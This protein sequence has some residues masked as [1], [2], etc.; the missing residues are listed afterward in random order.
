MASV[1][2]TGDQAPP[3]PPPPAETIVVHRPSLGWR[4]FGWVSILLGALLIAAA[5]FLLW[6]NTDSGRQ[7]IVK[8]VNDLQFASGLDITIERI[9]GSIWDEMTVH[10]LTLADERGVFFEAREAQ[11]RYSPI[12]YLTESHIDI[13]SLAIPYARLSRN[14][15]LKSTGDP[16][17]PLI[18]NLLLDIG[19]L[20]I[21]RLQIERPGEPPHVLSVSGEIHLKDSEALTNLRIRALAEQGRAGGDDISLKLDLAPE[22]NR[23]GIELLLDA[24]AN[25]FLASLTGIERRMRVDVRGRGEWANWQGWAKAAMDDQGFADLRVTAQNGRFSLSGPTRP[26]LFVTGPAERLTGPYTQLNTVFT[27]NDRRLTLEEFRL[28]SR[29]AVIVADGTVN[30]ADNVYEDLR[31]ATR[32]LQ[33]GAIAPNLAGRD[34]RLAMV[35]NGSMSTPRVAYDLRAASLSFSERTLVNFRATGAARVD[36]DRIV[37]PVA[38]S[39]DRLEGLPEQLGGLLTNVRLNGDLLVEGTNIVSDNLRLRSDRAD[40]VL[41]IAFDIGR[42]R[43]NV[44]IQGRVNEFLIESVGVVDITSDFDVVSQGGGFGLQGRVAVRTRRI[45]N[46]SAVDLLGGMATATARIAIGGDGAIRFGDLRVTAPQLRITEGGGVYYPDGRIALQLRGTSTRYGAIAVNVGGT[47]SAPQVRLEIAEVGF[48]VGLRG[49]TATIRATAGGY[50]IQAEGQSNY[51]PFS[52]DV[53][54][55]TGIARRT[56]YRI[57]SLLFA[58][59]TFRGQIEQTAQ[60]PFAGGLSVAGRGIDGNVVLAAAGPRQRVE[61]DAV[62]NDAVIPSTLSGQAEIAIQRAIVDL[63][64]T[65]PTDDDPFFLYAAGGRVEVAGL[66]SGAFTLAQG[67]A[68]LNFA[69]NAG[70]AKFLAVGSSGV[71]FN[72]AGNAA[73]TPERVR[74]ALQGSAN[75]IPFRFA[76]PAVIE[77]EGGD[78]ILRPTNV[79]FREGQGTMRLAGRFGSSGTIIQSRLDSFD[80][81]IAN[82]LRPGLG[83][84][85]HATGSLDF[86]LPTGGAFPRAEARLNIRNFTRT[87]IA[88]RSVPVDISFSGNLRPEGG[89]LAAVFRQNDAVIGRAQARLQPLPPGAGGWVDRLIAAPFSGGVRYNGPASV[90]TSLAGLSGHQLQGPVAVG[91]DFSG[92]INNPELVGVARAQ[93]VTYTNETYG[94]RISNLVLDG[95]F[96]GSQLDIVTL[97]G[98]AGDGTVRATGSIG[99]ASEAGYPVRIDAR[100]DNAR[101]AR[102]DDIAATATGDIQIRN[103]PNDRAIIRGRLE[104]GEIRYQIVRQA[105]ARVVNLTGVRRRG[106]PLISPAEQQRQRQAAAAAESMPSAWRL[107]LDLVADNRVF[108]SGM[109]LESEWAANL[110]VRGTTAAPVL[111]GNI[112]LVRGTLSFA[113]RRFNLDERSNITFPRSG[114]GVIN[115]QLEI[116]AAAE[117]DDVEVQVVVEGSATNPRITFA[118]N[119]NLPQDEVVS[120]ILFGSSVTEISAL[121]AIQLAASLNSLRGGGGG[122]LDPLGALQN[123]TGIDRLRILGA[124]DTTGRGTA[125]AAGFYLSDDIYIEI[126]TDAR[127]FTATQLEFSLS[128]TLS[129][130]SQF[131][132]QS[133]TNV[134]LRYSRDY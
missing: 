117:I 48:G 35:L 42:G 72:L 36:A 1:A 95:R 83:V 6:L 115:P 33:P 133:G 127:G 112:N 49:I 58:G 20:R 67:R 30:L 104:L 68:D 101:L 32:L 51:G 60:G 64:L 97:T 61:I 96:N 2:D 118:S 132:T 39:A 55:Q 116:I 62:A 125:L 106:Q 78:W 86:F 54:V 7:F 34:V 102:S 107:E 103:L 23:L 124:D 8:Q 63:N 74:L 114:D 80:I 119:P 113:G 56:I 57:N 19:A 98:R 131:G 70:T 66:R 38:A 26:D 134:N 69:G 16:D 73:I 108:V 99:F 59:M 92:R 12:D 37:V 91:A 128:R 9:D 77:R 93:N 11:L 105:S 122:G 81:A 47:I 120:R 5:A 87:G 76:Q 52:A 46:Q 31:I 28:N 27:F 85:G 126:I 88:M 17:A 129:L 89:A 13:Q 82:T 22:D 100:L 40:A 4:I 123:A 15:E 41:A 84:N 71:P 110:Q 3:S 18:P 53:L 43:Y 25:G 109:G 24:P 75:N 50:A 111:T 21:D 29:A 65:L 94:T 45:F 79:V 90:L 44:G 121:Q 14:P 130:L 10:G